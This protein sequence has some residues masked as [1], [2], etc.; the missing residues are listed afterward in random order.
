LEVSETKLLVVSD[1]LDEAGVKR[2]IDNAHVDK[3][4]KIID[5]H[6]MFYIE[7][8]HKSIENIQKLLR[9]LNANE[10]VIY[11]SPVLRDGRGVEGG[12]Y[13]N[14]VRVRLKSKEDYPVLQKNAENYLIK[15]I[16]ANEFNDVGYIL[17][18]PHNP[19]K[20]AMDVALELRETGLFEDAIPNLINF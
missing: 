13:T 4:K 12:S 17:T 14:E 15:E 20:D 8:Q 16:T 6:N 2:A 3:V 7:M 1:K 10:D 5:M 19:R 18:L 11:A 9:I